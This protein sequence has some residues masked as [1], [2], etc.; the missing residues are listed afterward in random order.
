MKAL[1]LES[2]D[3][4]AAIGEVAD[5][6]PGPGE[7]LVRV[8]AASVNAFDIGVAAG[9]MKEFMSYEFPVVIGN[10]LAGTVV[11]VGGGVEGFA[12][13]QRVFGMMGMKGV[14]HDGSFGELA[15][16]QAPSIA[17]APDGLSDADAGSLAVAG[18]T[19]MSAIEALDVG[20]GDRVLVVGAT[21]GVGTFA[22][23]LAALRGAHVIATVR[24]GDEAFVTDLGAAETLDYT[25]DPNAALRER[26][27]DGLDAALDAVNRDQAA[28]VTLAGLVCD[29][30]HA[31]SVVGG[32][33]DAVDIGGVMVS[34]TG[35]N[36]GHLRELADLV[37]RGSVRVAVRHT[38]PLDQAAQ[39]LHDFATE[40]TL[41]KLVISVPS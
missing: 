34:N 20:E 11:A 15:T 3:Q 21:G 36:P 29:G 6:E 13:G 25:T 37:V 12:V 2:F 9:A 40:H 10:D 24:P 27:P 32:A 33:G 39:A 41:G 7:V 8:A 16:P 23:Q 18:T 5:P 28:F 22:I 4:A 1:A 19:A 30:G 17:I 31:T 38:Y 14:L 26:Y 35:G